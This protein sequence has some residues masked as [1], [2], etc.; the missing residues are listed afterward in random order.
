M[1]IDYACVRQLHFPLETP[2]KVSLLTMRE[3][4]PFVVEVRDA[5]GRIGFGEALIVPGPLKR[6]R[7]HGGSAARWPSALLAGMPKRPL[8]SHAPR[9]MLVSALRVRCWP[10]LTCCPD[11]GCW[12]QLSIYRCLFSHPCMPKSLAR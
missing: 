8:Q 4:D 6:S 9:Y 1:K 7:A 3:F 11:T 2:Y 12:R 10:R 5:D